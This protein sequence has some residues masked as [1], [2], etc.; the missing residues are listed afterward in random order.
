MPAAVAIAVALGAAPSAHSTVQ[1]STSVRHVLTSINELPTRDDLETAF[2]SQ[3]PPVSALVGLEAIITNDAEDLGLQLRAIRS[4]PLFC[5]ASCATDQAHVL[6]VGVV[7]RYTNKVVSER[8]SKDTL[9]VRAAIEAL[10]VTK[11]PN[12][13]NLLKGF[14]ENSSRDIR[15]TTVHALRN[16]CNADAIPPLRARY[17]HEPVPQVSLAI[18]AALRDLTTCSGS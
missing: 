1:L 5:T 18:S 16:L 8:T 2:Q 11:I 12:D 4:L 3:Q 9:R 6:L 13:L 7:D 17:Q 14:L 15:T 10:G